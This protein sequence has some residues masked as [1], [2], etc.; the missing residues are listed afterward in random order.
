MALAMRFTIMFHRVCLKLE[1]NFIVKIWR[2]GYQKNLT[3]RLLKKFDEKIN[4]K[5]FVNP[6]E[7][8]VCQKCD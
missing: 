3:Q 6:F 2:K 7:K 8:H 1:E 4:E 5:F